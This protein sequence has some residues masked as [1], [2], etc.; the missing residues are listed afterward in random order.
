MAVEKP[1]RTRLIK[2]YWPAYRSRLF[3]LSLLCGVAVM[4]A[5][6]LVMLLFGVYAFDSWVLWVVAVT[7]GAGAFGLS[8][9]IAW[10]ASK[11]LHDVLAAVVYI[12]GE[13]SD[14]KPPNPNDARYENTSFG[15]ALQTV[16]A[17]AAHPEKDTSKKDTR[18]ASVLSSLNTSATGFA[19]LN[20]DRSVFFAS[21]AAPTHTVDGALQ[22]QLLFHG[23]DTL[24]TWLS[25]VDAE[26]IHAEKT[27]LRIP[28]RAA[29]VEGLRIFD[30]YASYEKGAAHEVVITCVDRTDYYSEGEDDLNFIAF[31]AHELRGPITVIRGYLDVL[32]DELDSA[33]ADDQKELFRRLTVSANRLSSYINN[34]L[35]TSRYDRRHLSVSL[36]EDTVAGVF[37]SIRDDMELRAASHH[38]ILSVTLPDSLPTIAADRSSLSEVFAN[39]ID[40]AIKYSSEGAPIAITAQQ[41]GEY[42]DVSVTDQGIGMPGNV[43]SNLFQK[44]YRSHRSRETVAGTGI[45]LYISK[46][47]IESHGGTIS[48][49]S[50]EGK[51]STFT[52]SLPTYASVAEKIQSGTN[53]SVISQGKGWIKNHSMF[54]G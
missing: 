37:A 49:R 51:G 14:I 46:A 45:G 42:V 16:Y 40:N 22:L 8:Q 5:V 24:D 53:T 15:D 21:T 50:E 52:V 18:S 6:I 30:V 36:S 12:A 4:A 34:I 54:R 20:K 31:A 26:A 44:F 38:Q 11:P 9:L 17:L 19:V 41:H 25:H 1:A 28:D 35:N 13:P 2:E 10:V 7:S 33:L 47:I 48:V 32:Q 27:W 39:L 23:D 29:D 3:V 43:V